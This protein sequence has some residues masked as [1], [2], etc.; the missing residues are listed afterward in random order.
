MNR[1]VFFTVVALLVTL[2][3][4]KK[5]NIESPKTVTDGTLVSF[6]LVDNSPIQEFSYTSDNQIYERVESYSYRK[7]IYNSQH[8][9]EKMELA[10]SYSPFSCAMPG[11]GTV[12]EGDDPRNAKVTQYFTFEYNAGKLAKKSSF[13]FTNNNFSL[14]SYETYL[15]EKGRIAKINN[16][17]PA[18]LLMNYQT[19]VIDDNGNITHADSYIVEAESIDKW[20]FSD[21]YEYDTKNNPYQVLACEGIPGINT[22]KN[23][24]T[25]KTSTSYYLGESKTVIETTYEYNAYDYPA[26]S[27]NINF[28]YLKPSSN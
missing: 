7:Y 15:Y 28:L 23:N 8:Q 2:S 22:N 20:I 27:G 10:I 6:A 13:Y 12:R 19:Y 24:I 16:Y 14:F 21:D 18:G 4:C 9:L 11:A 1:I 26:K 25:K 3:S 5:N 17:N